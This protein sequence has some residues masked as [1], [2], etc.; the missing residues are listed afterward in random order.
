MVVVTRAQK[1]LLLTMAENMADQ[2]P[3]L[4]DPEVLDDSRDNEP[5]C[6]N[7]AVNTQDLSQLEN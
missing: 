1:K 6:S 3:Q 2:A 5:V 7:E 4:L